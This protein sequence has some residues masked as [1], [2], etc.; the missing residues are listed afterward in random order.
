MHKAPYR[1]K[2]FFH[3]FAYAGHSLC[4]SYIHGM[5]DYIGTKFLEPGK[6]FFHLAICHV[7]LEMTVNLCRGGRLSCKLVCND[8]FLYF[9]VICHSTKP[10]RLF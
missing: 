1:A 4:I 10:V 3:A 7:S 8:P 5:V 9:T 6:V 2:R